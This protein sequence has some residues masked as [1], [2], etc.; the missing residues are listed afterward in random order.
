M[1]WERWDNAMPKQQDDAPTQDQP[2][3]YLAEFV[4][5]RHFYADAVEIDD[6]TFARGVAVPVDGDMAEYLRGHPDFKFHIKEATPPPSR[7]EALR[8]LSPKQRRLA[9]Q[10][11]SAEISAHLQSGA[12]L[13]TGATTPHGGGGSVGQGGVDAPGTVHTSTAA[14]PTPGSTPGTPPR[15][16]GAGSRGSRTSGTDSTD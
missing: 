6:L 3:S 5:G 10:R 4:A 2:T 15:A 7:D 8:G 13:T 14:D 11:Y 9:E 1:R 12:A 16:T